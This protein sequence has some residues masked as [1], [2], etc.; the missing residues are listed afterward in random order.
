MSDRVVVFIDWQNAYNRAR[1]VFH[2]S[3]GPAWHGQVNPMQLGQRVARKRTGRELSAVR[4]YRGLPANK[5][6]PRGYAASRR[7][8][9]AWKRAG[10]DRIHVNLRPLQYLA[11][12]PPREKGID[13]QLAVDFVTMAAR[14]EF[15]VGVLVSADTD[16]IPA[17]NAVH[18][19]NGRDQPWPEVAGWRGPF[20]Q[21]RITGTP[22]RRVAGIWID[23]EDYETMQDATDYNKRR[24]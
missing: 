5:R 1:Q 13:V 14:G 3:R 7:Q 23:Q 12:Q 20:G 21:R 4:V 9:A 8:A 6:D 18:D 24:Q 15:D 22:P 17:L 2:D 11:G 16:L 10:G 19:L